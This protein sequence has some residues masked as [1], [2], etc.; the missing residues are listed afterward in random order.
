ML[1]SELFEDLQIATTPDIRTI[2][3]HEF[4]ASY[5]ELILHLHTY[6]TFQSELL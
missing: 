3:G 6:L 2:Q 1:L 4:S 5:S